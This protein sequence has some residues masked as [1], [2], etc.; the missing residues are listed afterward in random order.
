MRILLTGF[1]AFGT[2]RVNPSEKIARSIAERG[3]RLGVGDLYVEILPTDYARAGRRIRQLLRRLRPEAVLC[4]GV[5]R[6]RT[7]IDLERF[8]LNLDDDPLPD[9]AGRVYS[10]RPIVRHGPLAYESTLPLERLWKALHRRGIPASISNHAGTFVCNHVFYVARHELEQMGR[11]IPCGLIHVPGISRERRG[12]RSAGRGL[13][14]QKMV[15]AMEC[16]L[17]VLRRSSRGVKR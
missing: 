13:P 4:L 8:A 14:L 10:G 15:E 9:N 6:S 2:L 16:C 5:A 11:E 17:Q 3:R 12:S 7:A 1:D